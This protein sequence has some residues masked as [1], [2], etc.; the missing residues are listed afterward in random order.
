MHGPVD[1]LHPALTE[2]GA[3]YIVNTVAV[4]PG[5]PMLLAR[6]PGPDGRDRFLADDAQVAVALEDGDPVAVA[7]DHA[8]GHPLTGDVQPDDHA[9]VLGAVERV[10]HGQQHGGS[11]HLGPLEIWIREECG[12]DQT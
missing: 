9:L 5:F 8:A 3:E 11:E 4:R 7:V 1:H 10:P 12:T 2:P 6:I